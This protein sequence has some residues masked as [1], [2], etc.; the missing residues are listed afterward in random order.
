MQAPDQGWHLR[1]LRYVKNDRLQVPIL[2][3]QKL[4]S[5]IPLQH[6]YRY[7]ENDSFL[8][9]NGGRAFFPLSLLSLWRSQ[10][11][12]K[13]IGAKDTMSFSQSFLTFLKILKTFDFFMMPFT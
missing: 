7:H 11:K 6:K 12:A 3:K 4:S 10:A 2:E 5:S 8:C 13:T 9:N 1:K